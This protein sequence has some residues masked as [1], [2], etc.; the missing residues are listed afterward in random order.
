[1]ERAEAA[2]SATRSAV[3]QERRMWERIHQLTDALTALQWPE[4]QVQLGVLPGLDH[5]AVMAPA[6]IDALALAQAPRGFL[7]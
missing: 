5:G 1:L 4:L 2:P 6:L 7:L 3:L